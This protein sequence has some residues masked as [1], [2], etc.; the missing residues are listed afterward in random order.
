VSKKAANT[1]PLVSV[2]IPAYNCEA[3]IED[4]IMS[5]VDQTYKTL[6]IIVIDDGST[7]A[8]WEIITKLAATDARIRPLRN[9]V[10]LR[11]VGTLN[12][13][14]TESKGK[15]IA[16]MDGDDIREKTSIE[17]QVAFLE[18]NP[19]CVV[20]GG[21]IDVCDGDMNVLNH[22]DYPLDDKAVRA[23]MFRFNPF[24]H[25][26][27]VIRRTAFENEAYELNW[28]EDYD[29]WFRLGNIGTLAN[30]PMTVLRL[31]THLASVSQSKISY[32]ENLTLYI[33]LK[34]VFE[35]GYKMTTGDKLYFAAQ[36]GSKWLIPARFRF[37]LFNKLR[38][39]KS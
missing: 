24:A 31:R 26:A 39:K 38:S 35:Y 22:R 33:R 19:E 32:Q 27:V 12:H 34:A 6:E 11:I 10:N 18:K 36:L 21:A 29:I 13:G 17:K 20:V 25:P 8:T 5:I 15:Y 4:A 23:K 3:Y 9:K 2:L 7:D 14:V 1:E 16:R 28:A 30:L 37:W